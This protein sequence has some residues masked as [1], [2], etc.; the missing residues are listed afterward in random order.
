M[1][2]RARTSTG[3]FPVLVE[4]VVMMGRYGHM[5]FLRMPVARRPHKVDE[6]LERVGMTRLRTPP[7]RRTQRRP[8][9]ARLPGARAGAGGPHHPARRAVHRRRRQDRGGDHRPAARTARGRAPD[10]GLDAQSRQR[11]GFLRPGRADQPHR[12][13]GRPDRR[14]VH[15]GQSGARLRRRAAPFQPGRRGAARRRRTHGA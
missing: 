2:R 14:G 10:A 13:G 11:A 6:A 7:D 12:A 9:E 8:E 3:T 1:C 5:N 4:D 15:P